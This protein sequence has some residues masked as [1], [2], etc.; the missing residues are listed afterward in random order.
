MPRRV[1]TRLVRGAVFAVC[2]V[3][4]GGMVA[5]SIA[6]DNAVAM[7]FGLTTAAAVAFLMVTTWLQTRSRRPEAEGE[8]TGAG[9][10][11]GRTPRPGGGTFT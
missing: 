11:G 6:D 10:H 8:G 4:I 5:G 1:S 3:G 9:V 2:V 7:A